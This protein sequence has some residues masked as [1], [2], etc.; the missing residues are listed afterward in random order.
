MTTISGIKSREKVVVQTGTIQFALGI[1]LSALSGV[2]LL[3]AFPPYGWWPLMWIACVPYRFAQYRLMPQK[4]SSVAETVAILV[5]LGPFMARMFGMD[6]GPFFYLLGVFIAILSFFLSKDRKF[7]EL[8]GYRWFILQGVVAWVGFEMVRATFIPLV[9]TSAFVGYTQSTQPWITQPISVFSVYGLNLIIMLVNFALT[10]G[11]MRW[12][13]RKW[14]FI[15]T[16]PVG[17]RQA[18]SGL[19]AM[20]AVLVVWFGISLALLNA[21]PKDMP[22]VRV[23]AI[24][25]GYSKG[26]F[27]DVVNTSQM[28][29]DAFAQDVHEAAAQGARIIFTPEMMFNF[30][31]QVE[32]TDEFRAL[33]AETDTYIFIDYTVSIEGQDW[34]NESI[35]LSPSGE[36]SAAYGK[37]EIPPGEPYTPTAGVYPVFDTPLGKLATMICHDANYTDT[38]RKLAANGAQLVSAG[39]NEF[40]GFGEQYWTNVSFR[41]IENRTAMVVTSR[42]TGS[43]IINPNGSPAA[44]DLEVGNHVVLVGDVTLGSG[45]A[46]YTSLGDILGWVSMIAFI[47]FIVYQS[48]VEKRAKKAA[49]S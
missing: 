26:A 12:S 27:Q 19:F 23:A 46:P 17:S 22:I 47:G 7:H 24:Q 5:W 6:N 18:R 48:L 10:L 14:Q 49:N 15:D 44:L 16:V 11:L 34:R 29:F 28:R 3:L 41:A 43:A 33:A 32:F 1:V 20:G 40:G 42:E 37:N 8:T 31:P 9:A 45:N 4:W 2:M 36:F 13:D 35:L 25:P 30:D 38:A 21:T 39:L